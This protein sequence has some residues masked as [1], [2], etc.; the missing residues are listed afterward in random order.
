[1]NQSIK[2][3][4]LA[5]TN[6]GNGEEKH[7]PNIFITNQTL[8]IGQLTNTKKKGNKEQKITKNLYTDPNIKFLVTCK[9]QHEGEGRETQKSQLNPERKYIPFS[10]RH[11]A[12][13]WQDGAA[14]RVV[15]VGVKG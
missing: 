14:R 8:N 10:I 11:Y 3:G 4:P 7:P 2:F 12:Q 15:E 9:H 1:M 5:N 6:T 13:F